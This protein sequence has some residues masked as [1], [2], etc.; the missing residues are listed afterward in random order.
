VFRY[1]LL[2][3]LLAI[4]ISHR[5]L[6]RYLSPSLRILFFDVGQGDSAL[7]RFPYG[8]TMLIDGGRSAGEREL[9][10][11]LTR[12]SILHLDRVVLSHPDQDHGYGLLGILHSMSVGEFWYNPTESNP[13][14]RS[15][16]KLAKPREFR[17]QTRFQ[18]NGV[19]VLAFPLRHSGARSNNRSLVILLDFNGCRAFFGG[20]MERQ[21]EKEILSSLV[22][23]L[24][25]LK[26]SHHGSKTSTTPE[27]LAHAKPRIAVI[28]VGIHNTYGHPHAQVLRR[29]S[30]RHSQILRTDFHGYVSIEMT[31]HG[32]VYCE[33]AQGSCGRTR[34][35]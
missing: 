27:F 24:T 10:L 28:S 4:F 17:T 35:Y 3:T 13:L 8:S 18:I 26:V 21:G 9:F 33:T 5:L 29:L 1:F 31:A 7:V 2:L 19:D 22:K 25:V 20:D 12:L 16:L 11:E 34:C 30:Y 32:E 6:D 15:L 14:L 23:P